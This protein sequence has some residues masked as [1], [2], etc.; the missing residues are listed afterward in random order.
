[1]INNK[2]LVSLATAGTLL[3]LSTPSFAVDDCSG[4]YLGIQGGYT[5][6]DYDL[7]E[8]LNEDFHKEELAGRAYVGFQFNRY[9][10]VETGFTM[11]AGTEL[12]DDFGDVKTTHWDLLVKAG[13][14]FGN[15][16][17]RADVKAGG[18][19]VMS[20]FDASDVAESVGL[21]DAKEW[22]IRPVAGASVSYNF[23]K[24]IAVD[25]SYFH[26]FGDPEDSTF[27]TPTVDVAM[28]GVSFLFTAL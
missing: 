15:S 27:G 6:A 13:V 8:F 9:F 18:A 16:G 21:D 1:M 25:A 7:E 28:V 14:P 19:H 22:K 4:I 26:V 11:L 24:N 17:F 12:P 2:L 10:G 3:G 23:N 20:K 5:R